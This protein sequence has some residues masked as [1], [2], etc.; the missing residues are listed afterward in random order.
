MATIWTRNVQTGIP[1]KHENMTL[2]INGDWKTAT[3]KNGHQTWYNC[4]HL[5][6]EEAERETREYCLSR[7]KEDKAYADKLYASSGIKL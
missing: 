7:L 5:T 6:R 2:Y 3:T 1:T 4:F